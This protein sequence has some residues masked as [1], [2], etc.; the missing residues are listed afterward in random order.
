MSLL[1]LHYHILLYI[2]ELLIP[3]FFSFVLLIHKGSH[4]E[5]YQKF[6]PSYDIF[7][8]WCQGLFRPQVL[9]TPAYAA[10]LLTLHRHIAN[11]QYRTANQI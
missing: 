1:R 4:R 10:Q 5:V 11:N 2:V 9:C 8:R 6:L 3:D 7:R